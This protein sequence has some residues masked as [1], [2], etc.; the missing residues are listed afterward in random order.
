MDTDVLADALGRSLKN[1]EQ[2]ATTKQINIEK[3]PPAKKARTAVNVEE[4][5]HFPMNSVK[6]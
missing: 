5:Q 6:Q 1:K 3:E 2:K 4:Q